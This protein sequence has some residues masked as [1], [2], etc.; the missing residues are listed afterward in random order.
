MPSIQSLKKE[1]RGIRSTQKLTKAMR[2]VSAAKFSKLN[3]AYGQYSGYG[4]QCKAVFD[5]YQ[6]DF[7]DAVQM[8]EP[9]A[10]PAYVVLASNKGL[11]GS[12]NAEVFKF[13]CDE[14]AKQDAFW[15]IACGKKTIRFF[16]GKNIPIKKGYVLQDVPTYEESSALLDDLLG[17]MKD[18][19]ISGVNV[20]YP[21]YVNMLDQQPAVCEL[22]PARNS[23]QPAGSGEP[24]AGKSEQPAGTGQPPAGSGEPPA[25]QAE[26]GSDT[27]KK[28]LCVPDKHTLIGKTAENLFRAMFYELVLEAALGAQAA[29][30][31]TM[32]TAY[33]A[34]TEFCEQLEGEINRKR[35]G[36]V[37]ADVIETSSGEA[38]KLGQL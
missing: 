6:A 33:D 16:S 28:V 19:K 4:R 9:A 29:T 17:L 20:I 37:T 2:T 22:F 12:F 35:Q 32:R 38:L 25:H 11:C 10:P 13:A 18:G 3:A 23:G 31:M 24:P 15:L 30:L 14:L 27:Q 5:E 34:A 1:L 8:T 21:R 36:T 26:G 7:L